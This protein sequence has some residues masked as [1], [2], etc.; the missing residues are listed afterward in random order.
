VFPFFASPLAFTQTDAFLTEYY[1]IN[2]GLSDR[3]V[4]SIIQNQEGFLWLATS[5][6]LN[7]FDG[8][9]FTIY[10]DHPANTRQISEVNTDFITEDAQGNI[11]ITYRNNYFLIDLLNPRTNEVKKISLLPGYGIMGIVRD[12]QMNADRELEVLSNHNDTLKVYRLLPDQNFELVVQFYQEHI[13]KTSPLSFTKL[14]NGHYLINDTEHG[15][16]TVN[17]EG[18]R[19]QEFHIEDFECMEQEY[20]FPGSTNIL[21]QDQLG[22][23]WVSFVQIP[24]VYLYNEQRNQFELLHGHETGYY[25]ALWEDNLGNVLL[26]KTT[27]IGAYPEVLDLFCITNQHTIEDFSHIINIGSQIVTIYGQ[28][29]FKTL[30]V[31]LDTGLKI[32]QNNKNKINTYLTQNIKEGERGIVMRG[33]TGDGNGTVYF[34]REV[35]NWYALNTETQELDTITLKHPQTGAKIDFNCCMDILYEDGILWGIS[36]QK[37]AYA[38]LIKYHIEQDSVELFIF[39]QRLT[40]FVKS[41]DGKFWL[42]YQ[43]TDKKGGLVSF[44][45]RTETW[46]K[47]KEKDDLN[48]FKDISPSYIME[49]SDDLLWIASDNGLFKVDRDKNQT[50][51]YQMPTEPGKKGLLSNNIFVIVEDAYRSLWIG[52]SNGLN[53]MNPQSEQIDSYDKTN[54]LANNQVCGI[55]PD[56]NGNFWIST[57]N[58]VSYF[59]TYSKLFKNF[60]K[61]DGLSDDEFNRFSFYKDE[62]DTYY[63]GG[64]N[65]MNAFK[66]EDLLTDEA[67]PPLVLTKLTKYNSQKDSLI[68]M[69]SNLNNIN[70]LVISPYDTYFQLNFS[71]PKYVQSK[72]NQF[73]SKLEGFE[74][75]WNYLGNTPQVRYNNLP[76]GNYTLLLKGADPNGNW[77]SIPYSVK[78]R[79]VPIFYKTLTARIIMAILLALLIWGVFQYQLEQ[80]LKVE[81]LRTKISSDLHDEVSGL[82]SGIAMQTDVLREISKDEASKSRLKSIGEVSRMAMTKMSD[83]IWSIDSRKDKVEDL[84]HRMQEHA[85]DILSPLNINYAFEIGKIDRG[86]KL[87]VDIRQNLYFIFKEAINNVVKHSKATEVVV[88][89]GNQGQKFELKIQDNGLGEMTQNST[90]KSKKTG[91]GLSNLK[92]RAQRINALLDII[93]QD[94][95]IIKLEMKKFA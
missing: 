40:A 26:P 82:L 2:D 78:I 5:N 85:E 76:A 47:Y 92:M 24:G 50:T 32:V 48:P 77:H 17:Q 23:I 80:R 89:L 18:K 64:V 43:S 36:C 13:N 74:N 37:S 65:G 88:Q 15:L 95:Y 1:S 22:R 7:K 12:I 66:K 87:P 62:Q 10:D 69:T 86:K 91:Q 8:Y 81:K 53:R 59:E 9:E 34:A 21:H 6:G 20:T 56:E 49:S 19:V 27:G 83:V 58:G 52:S 31:G 61:T 41:R 29:F 16:L 39:E 35:S 51:L 28:D 4:K 63:F 38:Q 42:T 3:L 54:G 79:V 46:D 90:A 11:I 73:V 84:I 67:I 33:I 25:T 45:P 94:G 55:I 14:Q 57:Y 70:E 75:N 71:L 68:V 60:Y 93:Q 72:K 44:D 30:F